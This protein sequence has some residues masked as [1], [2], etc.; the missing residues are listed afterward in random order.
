MSTAIWQVSN[1]GNQWFGATALSDGP[2]SPYSP[3]IWRTA[4]L[5]KGRGQLSVKFWRPVKKPVYIGHLGRQESDFDNRMAEY[6][7]MIPPQPKPP[8]SMILLAALIIVPGGLFVLAGLALRK[9]LKE[10]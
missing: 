8:M 9:Y 3:D 6:A 10:K 4:T 1:D 5:T 7:E 2:D